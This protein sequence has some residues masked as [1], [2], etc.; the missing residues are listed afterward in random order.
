MKRLILGIIIGGIF[1]GTSIFALS[2]YLYRSDEVSYTPSDTS[3]NVQNVEQALN[4]LKIQS[5]NLYN[6]GYNAG[7]NSGKSSAIK[8]IYK[9][10]VTV[11]GTG[12]K[13]IT[14]TAVDLSKTF[15]IA[16]ARNTS[17]VINNNNV[18]STVIGRLTSSTNLQLLY[19]CYSS[20][21]MVIDYTIIELNGGK[22]QSGLID[23]SGCSAQNISISSINLNKSFAIV[24][25][26]AKSVPE[27]GNSTS[28]VA[29]GQ[30]TSSTNLSVGWCSTYVS[31]YVFWQVVTFP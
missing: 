31:F 10:S 18:S 29:S 3:W 1:F 7:Y 9:G 5:A 24:S 12:S 8:N 20:Q 28:P 6:N 19:G 17:Q 23:T 4:D 26:G 14:I 13:N 22:V 2:N 30:L 16:T 27:N 21:S 11:S 25:A 15:V